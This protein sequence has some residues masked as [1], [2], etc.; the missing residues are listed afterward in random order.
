V[1]ARQQKAAALI[2]WLLLLAAFAIGVGLRVAN[3][4]RDPLWLDEAYSRYAASSSFAYLWT[5]VPLYETHPPLYYSLLRCWLL[6][7]GSSLSGLR[8]LGVSASIISL[9]VVGMAVAQIGRHLTWQRCQTAAAVITSVAFAGL[10]PLLMVMSRQVRPYPIMILVYAGTIAALFALARRRRAGR[11]LLSASYGAYLALLGLMLWLHNLGPLYGVTILIAFV[12]LAWCPA[13]SRSDWFAAA[14]GH[15]LV[16][17]CWLPAFLILKDQAPTWISHTWLTFDPAKLSD[18][19]ATIWA[20]ASWRGRYAALLLVLLTLISGLKGRE[21][22]RSIGALLVLAVLPVLLSILISMKLAPVFLV[23]T[24]S[25]VAIPA[26][27][28]FTIGV[29]ARPLVLQLVGAGSA[30]VLLLAMNDAD[31]RLLREPPEED[32]YRIIRWMAPQFK[33]GDMV[34]AYPNEGAM[35]FRYAMAD[36]RL[37]LPVRSIPSPVPALDSGADSWH[38]TGSRGVVS[39][40]RPRLE[41]IAKE[42]TVKSIPTIWLMRQ[43]AWTYDAGDNFLHAL[44][45]QDRAVIAHRRFHTIEF[46]ALRRKDLMNEEQQ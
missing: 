31:Q 3:M 8:A 12:V 34:F 46:H 36:M 40:S 33:P 1:G 17:L 39:L 41:A 26:V 15:A 44:E 25:P 24:L 11:A 16:G 45:G 43:G 14:A 38:P 6:L 27:L 5:V 37:D 13:W 9:A 35:A 42:A 7:V 22:A 30:I 10:F 32:W 4:H 23:R 28:L 18:K 21:E 29:V 19:L 20:V 2:F